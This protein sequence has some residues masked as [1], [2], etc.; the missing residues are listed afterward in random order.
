MEQPGV[1]EDHPEDPSQVVP[2]RCPG[3]DPVDRDPAPI[4]LVEAHE[5]VDQG[6]LARA[7]RAHD[8]D[9]LAGLDVQVQVVDQGL[10][11]FVA[12]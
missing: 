2:G 12:E 10:V 5:Q 7:G 6:R 3:V 8:C 11:W 9:R 4:D 1:L